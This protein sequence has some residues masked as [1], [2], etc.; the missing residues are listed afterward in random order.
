MPPP[1]IRERAS[2]GSGFPEVLPITDPFFPSRSF[3]F[4]EVGGQ[5]KKGKKT[6]PD[7]L[8]DIFVALAATRKRK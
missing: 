2:R 5:Q 1:Q 4:S 3:L 7:P 6:L 8:P